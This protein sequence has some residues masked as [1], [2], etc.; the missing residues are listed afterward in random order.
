MAEPSFQLLCMLHSLLVIAS[1]F[2]NTVHLPRSHGL[3]TNRSRKV[4]RGRSAHDVPQ[5]AQCPLIDVRVDS[6]QKSTVPFRY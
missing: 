5:D 4:E 2:L 3:A 6:S 1:H